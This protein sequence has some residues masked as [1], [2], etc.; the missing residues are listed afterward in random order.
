MKKPFSILLLLFWMCLIFYFSHQA[1]DES[2]DLS[3]NLVNFIVS[4]FS[5]VKPYAETLTFIVRKSAHFFLYFFLGI[6]TINLILEHNIYPKKR[7]LIAFVFCL[8]YAISDEIHQS[9]IP[10]RSGNI[11]DVLIDSA[12]SISGILFFLKIK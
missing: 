12:G 4:L 3:S 10:G 11:V 9:F 7:I 1:G 8:L 2:T 5:F 6:L